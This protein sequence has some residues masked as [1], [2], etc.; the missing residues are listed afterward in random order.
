MM[1]YTI[2]PVEEIFD[3]LF[4]DNVPRFEIIRGGL[5]M[6]V[7]QVGNTQGRIVRLFST[8]PQD[9]LNPAWQPGMLINLAEN[10]IPAYTD[11][12]QL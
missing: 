11:Q 5:S 10:E 2:T 9:Y 3:E 1:F 12:Q 8:D 7:E 4:A 6:Q